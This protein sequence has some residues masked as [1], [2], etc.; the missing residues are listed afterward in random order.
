[1]PKRGNRVDT[2]HKRNQTSNWLPRTD[3]A[4]AGLDRDWL[5][6]PHSS[7][8]AGLQCGQGDC[9]KDAVRVSDLAHV[10]LSLDRICSTGFP[11]GTPLSVRNSWM[12]KKP[13]TIDPGR[14]AVCV[15]RC[16]RHAGPVLDV[17]RC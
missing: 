6:S 5:T 12:G 4:A 14:A 8:F 1:M 9:H 2:G 13:W 11:F 16:C 17:A 15:C 10:L 3:S 7:L